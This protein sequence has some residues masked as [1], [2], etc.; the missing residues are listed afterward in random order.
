MARIARIEI[1]R[2]FA[3][4]DKEAT[5]YTVAV[6]VS[7][8]ESADRVFDNLEKVMGALRPISTHWVEHLKKLDKESLDPDL[9]PQYREAIAKDL[10]AEYKKLEFMLERREKALRTLNQ[11]GGAVN[12]VDSK[13]E[14]MEEIKF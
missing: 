9:S 3:L 13:I 7:G 12:W 1:S 14:Y 4:D 11:L 6:E 5:T 8:T 10:V 2:T